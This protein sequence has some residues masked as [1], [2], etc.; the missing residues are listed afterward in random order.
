MLL[1]TGLGV[2][3]LFCLGAVRVHRVR[4]NYQVS[5]E[6]RQRERELHHV[7]RAYRA[8]EAYVASQQVRDLQRA[9][10]SKVSGPAVPA[11]RATRG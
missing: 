11:R 2:V 7:Q 1:L 9:E 5:L 4:H 8:L 10:L 3:G 6:L